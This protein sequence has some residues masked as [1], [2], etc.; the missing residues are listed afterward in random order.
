M[1]KRDSYLNR[2]IRHMWNG[3]I[4]VITSIRRCGK[5]VRFIFL[6]MRFSL[7]QKLLIKKM[8]ESKLFQVSLE[9][10]RREECT[11]A[12]LDVAYTM[13]LA[14]RRTDDTNIDHYYFKINAIQRSYGQ[15]IKSYCIR[16]SSVPGSISLYSSSHPVRP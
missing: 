8:A 3:E 16:S 1:I 7:P 5:S 2:M 10:G 11:S 6:S 12:I 13:P 14:C 9:R 15:S 4:K